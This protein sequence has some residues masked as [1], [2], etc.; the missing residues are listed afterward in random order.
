[1]KVSRFLALIL[2][3]AAAISFT[4]AATVADSIRGR[5][6]W[7]SKVVVDGEA[8]DLV[9]GT[10]I[11]IHF[12]ITRDD[13]DY[14]SAYCGCNTAGCQ[15]SISEG[16]LI[17]DPCGMLMEDMMP[18]IALHGQE[19]FMVKFVTSRPKVEVLDDDRIVLRTE[20]T[21]ITFVDRVVA[22]PDRPLVGTRWDA[23]GFSDGFTFSS[24]RVSKTGWIHLRPGGKLSFFD[25]RTEHHDGIYAVDETDQTITFSN[26]ESST[27]D[28]YTTKFHTI[29]DTNTAVTYDIVGPSLNIK[30]ADGKGVSFRAS[31]DDPPA[32]APGALSFLSRFRGGI[33][34]PFLKRKR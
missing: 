17:L 5:T 8:K 11:I 32:T 28:R 31:D 3:F 6:F 21:I 26:V 27:C 2:S 25:G 34:I 14:F 22:D 9:P 13:G 10:R 16:R 18:G 1:M 24:Y 29:F 4:S 12:E 30:T 33:G 19:E 15:Y 23:I 20:S 7:S